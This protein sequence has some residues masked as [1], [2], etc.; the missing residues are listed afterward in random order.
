MKRWVANP[1]HHPD[2]SS[3][4]QR[5]SHEFHGDPVR[6]MARPLRSWHRGARHYRRHTRTHTWSN[7]TDCQHGES[8]SR[9]TLT[10]PRETSN[11]GSMQARASQPDN[12]QNV[13]DGRSHEQIHY[14]DVRHMV[15]Q[16]GA[17]FPE[18]YIR[19][20]TS[21]LRRQNCDHVNFHEVGRIGEPRHLHCSHLG[22]FASGGDNAQNR[23]GH[24]VHADHANP[25]LGIVSL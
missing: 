25:V 5:S 8:C 2:V 22:H 9:V 11:V 12:R 16:E 21:P 20:Y 23:V 18:N 14:R 10:S 24:A 3:P 4:W 1:T 15:A 17:F 19:A 7:A 13:G 6:L